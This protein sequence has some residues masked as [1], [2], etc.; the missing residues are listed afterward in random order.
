MYNIQKK[1]VA[2]LSDYE[3]GDLLTHCSEFF[4]ITLKKESVWAFTYM[5]QRKYNFVT[6]EKILNACTNFASSQEQG[7]R[8][9]PALLSHILIT[10][11]KGQANEYKTYE[12]T[13]EQKAFYKQ[14]WLKAVYA[15]FDDYCNKIEP[16]RI[17]IWRFIC[18][19]LREAGIITAE[20][21][22][23]ADKKDMGQTFT[24]H[25]EFK[26]LCLKGF[27]TLAMT[28]NHISKFINQ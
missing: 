23:V 28:N 22:D 8:F 13:E 21:Y 27:N 15:D 10:A 6:D 3:L 16:T 2:Y 18:I 19:Q 12:T 11:N 4:G 9:S 25:S 14:E 17:H 26:M 5:L 20:D 7:K 1:Q 24:F